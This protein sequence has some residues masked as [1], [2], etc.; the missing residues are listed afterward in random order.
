MDYCVTVELFASR[1]NIVISFIRCGVLKIGRVA[2]NRVAV[3]YSVSAKN[4]RED[5]S[6]TIVCKVRTLIYIQSVLG[7]TR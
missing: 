5:D 6:F 4:R 3:D 2:T 1:L 7:V